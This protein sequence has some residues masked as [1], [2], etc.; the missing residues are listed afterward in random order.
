MM[1]QILKEVVEALEAAGF[2]V[3]TRPQE[4]LDPYKEVV[5][6]VNDVRVELE[7]PRSYVV[8]L[9]LSITFIAIDRVRMLDIIETIIGTIER[10]GIPS[11]DSF[12]IADVMFDILGDFVMAT[13]NVEIKG[14]MS[15][16]SK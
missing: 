4:K 2:K 8:T 3:N 12:E 14:V 1:S 7:T 11:A 10:H 13:I 5:V 15:F 16:D 6:D 9:T